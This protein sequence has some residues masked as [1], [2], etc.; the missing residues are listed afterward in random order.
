MK[1]EGKGG[2]KTSSGEKF[3]R[4]TLR[5]LRKDLLKEGY[6]LTK[7]ECKPKS[8][9]GDSKK[10]KSYKYINITRGGKSCGIILIKSEFVNYLK[11]KGINPKDHV[12]KVE[13]PD[14]VIIT[15][16]YCHVI[17]VKYQSVAGSVDEKIETS[18]FKIRQFRKMVSNLGIDTTYTYVFNDWFK[19][20]RYTDMLDYIIELKNN[21]VYNELKC[22]DIGF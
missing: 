1:E 13:I 20:H 5:A 19:Q 16:K 8:K 11:N 3:E 12:S 6:N 7:K 2:S 22:S 18:G 14:Y 17:E 15:D 9:K 4:K 21:Y 10:L